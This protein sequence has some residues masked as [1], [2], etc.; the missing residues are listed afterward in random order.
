MSDEFRALQETL[1]GL[2]ALNMQSMQSDA[3]TITARSYS[4]RV[5]HPYG[6]K[7]GEEIRYAVVRV[8]G[9]G[10]QGTVNEVVNLHNGEHYARKEVPWRKIQE[11]KVENESMFKGRVK[12]EVYLVKKAKHVRIPCHQLTQCSLLHQDHIVPFCST[13]AGR[14]GR[15]L[16]STCRFVVATSKIC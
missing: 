10:G 7:P 11:R 16:Q 6:L 3:S 14:R 8:L 4:H 15:F 1:E 5:R 2:E 13:K 12:R 9:A